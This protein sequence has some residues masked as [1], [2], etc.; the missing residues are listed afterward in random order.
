[1]RGGKGKR[2][3]KRLGFLTE[4]PK[5]DQKA[6]L[7]AILSPH[8][9]CSGSQALKGP[10]A[11]L[12]PQASPDCMGIKESLEVQDQFTFLNCQVRNGAFLHLLLLRCD[13]GFKSW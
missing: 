2:P 13:C 9:S 4:H 10:V 3:P 6:T 1:M 5:G 8:N 12:G 11:S 7:F